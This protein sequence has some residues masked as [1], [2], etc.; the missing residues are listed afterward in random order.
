MVAEAGAM[1][2]AVA[3]LLGVHQ[4]TRHTSGQYILNYARFV[5]PGD[6]SCM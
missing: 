1:G 2:T 3:A 5:S 6:E 4:R